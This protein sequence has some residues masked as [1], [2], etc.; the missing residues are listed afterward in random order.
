QRVVLQ[1]L[2]LCGV[3][4]F[5]QA[6]AAIAGGTPMVM[7]PSF[8][9][10]EAARLIERHGITDFNG[11]DEMFARLLATRDAEVLFP[12]LRS[13]AYAAFNPTMEGIVHEAE[14]RDIRLAGLYGM[15]EV[16]ALFARQ[17]DA[18]PAAVRGKPGGFPVGDEYEVRVRDPDSGRLLAAGESGE[19]EFR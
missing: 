13:G 3:F 11:T 1:S 14:R 8:E 16:Q 17:R 6:L 19:L 7:Q 5:C 10:E 12:T 9:A 2:P 18:A 4:G 15:S